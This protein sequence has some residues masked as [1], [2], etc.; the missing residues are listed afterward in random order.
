MNIDQT[1]G[2]VTATLPLGETI[3][4]GGKLSVPVLVKYTDQATGEKK[5]EEIKAQFIATRKYKTTTNEEYKSVI[6]FETE[7]IYD[8]DIPEGYFFEA[9]AGQNGELTTTF[10]QDTL[11]GK[12]GI[13]LQ[14]GTFKEG[15]RNIDAKITKDPVKRIVKIGAKPTTTKVEIPF[16][17]EYILDDTLE[18]GKTETIREGVKGEKTI[19]TERNEDARITLRKETTKEAIN[20]QVKIGTKT[21]G[22]II[23]TDKIHLITRWNLT[24][25]SIPII[26][27][28]R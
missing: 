14:D 10:V 25:T 12:K 13:F 4:G 15:A 28:K 21:S 7:I 11:N 1:T 8:E 18:A 26:Q 3:E 9:Q 24:L 5:T 23:D 22:E 6:P 2:V 16:D 19:T 27:M 17:T 20:K